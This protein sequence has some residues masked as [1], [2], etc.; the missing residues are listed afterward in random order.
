M[1]V[2]EREMKCEDMAERESM[3]K[4]KG[5]DLRIGLIKCCEAAECSRKGK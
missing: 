4:G 1:L 2:W 5:Y 3:K